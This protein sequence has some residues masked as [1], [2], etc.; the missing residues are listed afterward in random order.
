MWVAGPGALLVAKLHKIAERAGAQDRVRDK[1]ALDIF[2]MLRAVPTAVLVD[3]LRVLANSDLAG[4]V[5]E[6]A[7][8]HLNDLF[9]SAGNEGVTMIV[10]AAGAD[11][12]ASTIEASAVALVNDLLGAL[13]WLP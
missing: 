1:D 2:R 3:R 5:T 8:A 6:E 10:R 13:E 12:D 4:G 11:E 9:A 7:M